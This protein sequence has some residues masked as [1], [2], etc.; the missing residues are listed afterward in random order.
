MKTET[1]GLTEDGLLLKRTYYASLVYPFPLVR[2]TA[3]CACKRSAKLQSPKY[4]PKGV[5]LLG[6]KTQELSECFRQRVQRDIQYEKNNVVLNRRKSILVDPK[7]KMMVIEN[8]QN[9]SSYSGK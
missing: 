3:F 1:K 8:E 4:T 2:Y 5:T 6:L 7:Y 9:R